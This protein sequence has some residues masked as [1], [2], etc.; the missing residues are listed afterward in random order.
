MDSLEPTATKTP[1]P[2]ATDL[3]PPRKVK[4][5]EDHVMASRETR[6]E[7]VSVPPTTTYLPFPH[8]IP[9]SSDVVPVVRA[10]QVL[11]SDDVRTVPSRPT[12]MNLL[13]RPDHVPERRQTGRADVCPGLAVRGLEYSPLV[14]VQVIAD[15]NERALP[16]CE[17]DQVRPA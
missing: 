17:R 9:E 12:Q 4:V 13:F 10:L 7:F 3:S 5:A 16:V 8:A 6:T 11:P 14:D 15:S 2:K 1:A